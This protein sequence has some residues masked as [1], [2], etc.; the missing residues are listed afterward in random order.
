M[1]DQTS[2]DGA[3]PPEFAGQTLPYQAFLEKLLAECPDV[4]QEIRQILQEP[5]A[6]SRAE[7]GRQGRSEPGAL[8]R[9]PEEGRG[10]LEEPV[11][12]LLA[13]PLA[14]A[15]VLCLQEG[16][17]ATPAEIERY[18]QLGWL[19]A[20]ISMGEPPRP[21]YRDADYLPARIRFL[22][23]LAQQMGYSEQ[24]ITEIAQWQDRLLD[25]LVDWTQR[26][27]PPDSIESGQEAKK[28]GRQKDGA[29]ADSATVL[30][31]QLRSENAFLR[32]ELERHAQ[33]EAELRQ[34]MKADKSEIARLRRRLAAYEGLE[35]AS[36]ETQHQPRRK[37]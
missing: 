14:Q 13:L 1:S 18:V 9:K 34:L 12:S 33:A 37:R 7:P 6:V 16:V 2:L 15:I 32:S 36:T 5:K 22:R 28:S 20:P 26:W 30:I 29:A 31:E 8:E 3:D 23:A 24:D 17:E 35:P 25:V 11:D 4:A 10:R 27:S 21:F 19:P